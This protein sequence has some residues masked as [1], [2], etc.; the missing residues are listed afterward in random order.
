MNIIRVLYII[1]G[2]LSL[3]LG[4]IGTVVPILPTTPFLLLTAY[5][6]AKGSDKFYN[7]FTSTKIYKKYLESFVKNRS[8]TLQTKCVILSTASLMLLFPL[9]ILD[10]IYVRG[11]IIF[12]YI[13]KYYY[14]FTKIKTIKVITNQ[15]NISL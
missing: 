9:F 3:A 15:S 11:L 7:W 14:F 5:C 1:A 8:M 4:V 2:S 10:N 6:Y 12:L 13:Y